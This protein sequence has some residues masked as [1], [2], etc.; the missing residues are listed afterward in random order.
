M[1]AVGV[2][3]VLRGATAL[4]LLLVQCVLALL[5]APLLAS[6]LA[7]LLVAGAFAFGP[8][9]ARS[10]SLGDYVADANLGLLNASAQFMG[11]LKLAISQD[12]Q[13]SFVS[14]VRQ[15]LRDLAERQL[16]FARQQVL[17][18]SAL[19]VLIAVLGVLIVFAG[20]SWFR[21]APS[22]LVALLVIVTRMTAPIAQVQQAAEQFVH[23]LAVHDRMRQ[24]QDELGCAAAGAES[25]TGK[26]CPDGDIAFRNVTFVRPSS[27]SAP[28]RQMSAV[29]HDLSLTIKRG[30]FLVL[31]GA[32]GAGKTTFV[33]LLAG[34]LS[35]T[36]GRIAV[37]DDT[38][39]STIMADWRKRLAYVPQDSFLFNDSIRRNLSWANPDAGEAQMW[40]ALEITEAAKLVRGMK[41]GLDTVVG[42]RGVLVSGGE[43]QRIALARALLRKPLLLILDEATSAL[44]RESERR[45]LAELRSMAPRP[46]IVL[47]A[48][49]TENLAASDRVIGLDGAG[50]QQCT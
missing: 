20:L 17:G 37:G 47:V 36:S 19:V 12:L 38:L 16:R 7:V 22:L 23:L 1:S 10:R 35:P 13:P 18:Q 5:L 25:G 45:I 44:D 15:T 48:H 33:D 40:Q 14:L 3:Y 4:I 21:L 41:D 2:H 43:R 24:L 11:G 50:V 31:T 42:E 29:L 6:V 28:D 34:L 30:E 46:T 27:S 26:A 8:M 32:S 49:R 9:L 39:D